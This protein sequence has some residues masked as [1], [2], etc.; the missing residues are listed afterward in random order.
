MHS[1]FDV[2]IAVFVGTW[3][4]RLQRGGFFFNLLS[5]EEPQRICALSSSCF[6]SQQR[7][8]GLWGQGQAVQGS[9]TC[10]HCMSR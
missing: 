9:S 5:A 1:H 7:Q 4:Y 6:P 8:T 3:L 10:H 2:F